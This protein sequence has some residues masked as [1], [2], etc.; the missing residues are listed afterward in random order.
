MSAGVPP[1]RREAFSQ[2][3]DWRDFSPRQLSV[4]MFLHGYTTDPAEEF[5]IAAALPLALEHL[6]RAA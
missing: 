1:I 5:E 2:R 3:P 6:E 4:L